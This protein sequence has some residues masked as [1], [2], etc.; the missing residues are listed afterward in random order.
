MCTKEGEEERGGER[1]REWSER[2]AII[3][4][5][6]AYMPLISAVGRNL[7]VGGAKFHGHHG[8]RA[9]PLPQPARGVL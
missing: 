5:C 8:G 3:D 2:E 4:K 7:K 6:V 1:E 9:V